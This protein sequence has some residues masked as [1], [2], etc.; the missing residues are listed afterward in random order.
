MQLKIVYTKK[1]LMYIIKLFFTKLKGIFMKEA[2]DLIEQKIND[3]TIR[4]KA[5]EMQKEYLCGGIAQLK[6]LLFTIKNNE[7]NKNKQKN[8][9]TIKDIPDYNNFIQHNCC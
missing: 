7:T 9:K 3:L 6:T 4:I 1:I 5:N 2:I 8:Y